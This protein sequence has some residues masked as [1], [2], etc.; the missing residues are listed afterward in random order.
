[1]QG[2]ALDPADVRIL[3]YLQAHGRASNAELAD[4]A[5]LSASQCHRRVKRLESE[6]IIRGYR[7][8]LDPASVGLDISAFVHVSLS[9]HGESPAT[10]FVDALDDL[11]EVLECYSLAGDTDYLL[12]VVMPNLQAFSDFLMHTLMPMPGIGSV[13]SY[14]V[15][16]EIRREGALPLGAPDRP[17][18]KA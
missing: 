3:A 7:A 10:A 11:P 14:V 6:G 4:V 18:R 5:F 17:R 15:L 12:K 2:M 1:M 16:E 9:A 13:K 8:E